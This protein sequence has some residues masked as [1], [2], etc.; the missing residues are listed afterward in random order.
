ML[1]PSH[2]GD[3]Y[4][5]SKSL[6]IKNRQVIDF[7][8]NIN[9]YSPNLTIDFNQLSISKYAEL[10]YKKLKKKLATHYQSKANQIAL[11]NGASVAIETFLRTLN[12]P[13]TLYAPA[14]GEYKRFAPKAQLINRFDDIYTPPR[15]NNLVIF[16]NP[17]TPDGLSYDLETLFEIWERENNTI[18][19]DESFLEFTKTA[20]VIK[21]LKKNDKLYIL[22]SLTKFYACA[23]V[24]VGIIISTPKNIQIL[25]QNQPLWQVSTFDM[26]YILEALKDIAFKKV[27]LKKIKRDKKR[28]LKLLKKSPFIA[29]IYP[30]DANFFLI[31]LK[32]LD[33]DTLQKRC[34]KERIMI[35][36]CENFDFLDKQHVRL[37]VRRKKDVKKLA[38]VLLHA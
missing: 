19:I 4:T 15:K 13:V 24:R 7:S 33:A 34:N 29:K 27:V 23:G 12:R 11:Y 36:N 9:Q 18:L 25:T 30:S 17:A 2:G 28:L 6:G 37:A 1:N 21:R 32:G 10:S 3:I 35:R 22:K 26:H 8:S 14:Y 5:F 31:L 16:V 20:S 38:K